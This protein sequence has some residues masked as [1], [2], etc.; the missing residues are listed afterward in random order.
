VP[1]RFDPIDH[2]LALDLGAR[3]IGAFFTP[4]AAAA[5]ASALREARRAII[6][7]GFT[8][9]AETPET[10]GPPGAAA[11]GRALRLSGAQVRYVTDPHNVPILEAA[12]KTHDEPVDILVYPEGEGHAAT[13]LAR[14]RP[15][16]LI[17]IERPGRALSGDYLNLRGAPIGAWNRR[18][19][20]L[21]IAAR[22]AGGRRPVTVGIGDGGNEIGMGNVR[23]RLVRQRSP[24]AP[25]ASIVRV[26]HL[27]VAGTSNWGGYGIAAALGRLRGRDLLHLP[28]TE[29]RVIEACV[30]AGAFD[31][32]T[33]K[34]APTVDGL[35][36]DVHAAVVELFRAASAAAARR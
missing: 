9:A 17:A 15:S 27:V 22:V 35:P 24:L 23:A 5:A 28:E 14:E 25:I 26:D 21:F 7:T 10:D 8:V 4:G 16:H 18:V 29:A 11:L 20:E 36:V 32:V 6:A 2:V 13:W 3:G 19:D 30:A 12:L 1:G 31:G 33:R 34:R